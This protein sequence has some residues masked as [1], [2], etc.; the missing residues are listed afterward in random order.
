[1]GRK[2]LGTIS[3]V[4]LYIVASALILGFAQ[5]YTI[6]FKNQ[7]LITTGV[8]EVGTY[9]TQAVVSVDG[10]TLKDSTPVSM[11][12]YMPGTYSLH[13]ELA[14]Y[15]PLDISTIVSPHVVTRLRELP[16]W[17]EKNNWQ[18]S[19]DSTDPIIGLDPLPQTGLL[20][21]RTEKDVT[22]L[23]P[24][25]NGELQRALVIPVTS[26][27]YVLCSAN[28]EACVVAGDE[29][30]ILVNTVE[31]SYKVLLDVIERKE[32]MRFFRFQANYFILSHQNATLTLEKIVPTGNVSK[33]LEIQ[34]VDAFDL[35]GQEI[36]FVQ[37]NTLYRQS[38]IS[39]LQQATTTISTTVDN[40]GVSNEYVV[41]HTLTGQVTLWRRSNESLT[42][43]NTWSNARFFLKAGRIMIV[44]AAKV[45]I[46]DVEDG[47]Q[48]VGQAPSEITF[49]QIY[50]T[51]A[52]LA[53]SADGKL[54]MIMSSPLGIYTIEED[55][56]KAAV[57]PYQG[58]AVWHNQQIKFHSYPVRTWLKALTS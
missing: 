19:F 48:F 20:L 17:P 27:E 44:S 38:L 39:G 1:M 55:T 40:V 35:A 26:K 43:V 42:L 18:G 57:L 49:A 11:S 41:V 53:N 15:Q 47:V 24:L 5:G 29:R 6:D 54:H 50:S 8:L 32:D 51:Y 12:H 4:L 2:W 31:L 58:I 33:E 16:L 23:K 9:P 34:D 28:D 37:N 7:Q 52:W 3:V 36:W 45:W 25:A 46:V 56:N 13:I 21:M 30:T 14:G 10:K 22:W